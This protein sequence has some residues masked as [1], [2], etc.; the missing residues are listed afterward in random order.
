MHSKEHKR[1]NVALAQI[2]A[3]GP[4]IET[5]AARVLGARSGG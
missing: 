2:F 5:L 1:S 3:D 4:K